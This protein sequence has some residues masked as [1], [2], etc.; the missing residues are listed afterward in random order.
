MHKQCSSSDKSTCYTYY[1]SQNCNQSVN[2]KL[3]KRAHQCVENTFCR[4]CKDY[5]S[6]EHQCC[7]QPANLNDVKKR[8]TNGLTADGGK[9][10]G[11][12]H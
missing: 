7:M 11:G 4:T 9:Q 3:H 1:R 12:R 6:E 2:N 5:V 8:N 10:K